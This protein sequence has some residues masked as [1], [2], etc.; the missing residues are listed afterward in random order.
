MFETA[1]IKK[2]ILAKRV[3]VASYARENKAVLEKHRSYASLD[4]LE[5][6]LENA[7]FTLS[8]LNYKYECRFQ[9]NGGDTLFVF[10]NG[11]RRLKKN[12]APAPLFSRWSYAPLLSGSLL[13]IDDPMIYKYEGLKLGWYYGDEHES[14]IHL[15]IEIVKA[16]CRHEKVKQEHVVFFGSSGGGYAALFSATILQGTLAIALN[17]QIRLD[18]FPYAGEFEKLTGFHLLGEDY[19]GRNNLPAAM[20]GS[21]SKFL[22]LSN[23][24]SC[25]DIEHHVRSLCEAYGMQPA[26]GLACRENLALWIYDAVGNPSPHNSVETKDILPFILEIGSRFRAGVLNESDCARVGCVN[27]L[28]HQI[29]DMRKEQSVA[30]QRLRGWIQFDVQIYPE[31]KQYRIGDEIVAAI[32]SDS[33]VMGQATYAFYLMRFGVLAVKS[34]YGMDNIRT[35]VLREAG[36]YSVTGFVKNRNGDIVMIHSRYFIVE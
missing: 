34:L 7:Q 5:K 27:E 36:E 32:R 8:L 15:A 17:P 1:D 31:K 35:F 3:R 12:V 9:K 13:C 25:E 30:M 22:C 10:Y 23:A 2:Q 33:M 6:N 11:A 20:K 18:K 24:E 28:W 16:V 26:Y 29:F 14:C 21:Q 4:E 19:F